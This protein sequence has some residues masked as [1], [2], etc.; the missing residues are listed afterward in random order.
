M[1]FSIIINVVQIVF[2]T[3][4]RIGQISNFLLLF[5]FCLVLFFVLLACWKIFGSMLTAASE[6]KKRLALIKEAKYNKH[7]FLF[8]SFVAILASSL[9]YLW[10]FN[11]SIENGF[12]IALIGALVALS[13]KS[14]KGLIL[15][16]FVFSL[17]EAISVFLFPSGF[18]DIIPL[19]FLIGLILFRGEKNGL[20]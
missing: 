5:S 3:V 20:F 17:L 19:V 16:S 2:G 15:F 7:I 1:V 6:D 11:I 10:V 8:V 12:R 4:P 13:S 18:K 14:F 9:E